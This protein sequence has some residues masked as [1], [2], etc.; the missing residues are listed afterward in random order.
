MTL[1]DGTDAKSMSR[2]EL[3]HRAIHNWLTE[4]A[5]RMC[6]DAPL[7][8]KPTLTL[9]YRYY[10]RFVKALHPLRAALSHPN[11]K[12]D[13]VSQDYKNVNENMDLAWKA[14]NDGDVATLKRMVEDLRKEQLQII[15]AMG[16]CHT[17]IN[18]IH[19]LVE[20]LVA[21]GENEVEEWLTYAY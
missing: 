4:L 3:E 19:D 1:K 16:T 9:L 10:C 18:K 14:S 17:E 21:V 5:R 11:L 20:S 8:V 2:L 6:S 12:T 15:R 13:L 7:T